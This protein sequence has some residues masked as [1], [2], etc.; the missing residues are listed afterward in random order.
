MLRIL[1]PI[2][3]IL[4]SGVARVWAQAVSSNRCAAWA[5]PL[6]VE[7]LGQS[8]EAD[9]VLQPPESSSSAGSSLALHDLQLSQLDPSEFTPLTDPVVVFQMDLA[10]KEAPIPLTEQKVTTSPAI[11]SGSCDAI[12][13]WWDCWTDPDCSV[14]LSCAPSF[15]THHPDKHK[16]PWRDHWMQA[17]YYPQSSTIAQQGEPLSL[18]ACHDEYS[19]WFDVL[20]ERPEAPLPM[21]QPQPGLQMAMSRYHTHFLKLALLVSIIY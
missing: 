19:M 14:L 11:A 2:F 21:P 6:P 4:Y 10:C 7:L 15:A 8:G 1:T 20:L 3:L 16:I 12:F 5:K 9:V 17:I 18:V 13:M